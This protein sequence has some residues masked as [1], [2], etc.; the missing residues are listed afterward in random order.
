M[1]DED[2]LL[3]LEYLD[4]HRHTLQHRPRFQIV[5]YDGA[6][7]L[8]EDEQALGGRP[9]VGGASEEHE[10]ARAEDEGPRALPVT[11]TEHICLPSEL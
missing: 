8:L 9:P 6:D 4:R 10:E 11:V 2:G 3:L 7:R 5:F 1:I